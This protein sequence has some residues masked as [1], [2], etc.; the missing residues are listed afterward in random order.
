MWKDMKKS[1]HVHT[2]ILSNYN[3]NKVQAGN[4]DDPESLDKYLKAGNSST[5]YLSAD[6]NDYGINDVAALA[7]EIGHAWRIN[8]G[9]DPEY[10]GSDDSFENKVYAYKHSQ[11]AEYEALHIENIIRSEIGMDAREEYSNVGDFT[12]NDVWTLESKLLDVSKNKM[13][14]FSK[15][16]KIKIKKNTTYDYSS[17]RQHYELLKKRTKPKTAFDVTRNTSSKDFP[18]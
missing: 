16:K 5:I 9:L 17:N 7:H 2:I 14:D 8:G 12:I 3:D 15:L 11:Y 18:K 10:D 13:L 6:G 4:Q 1:Q